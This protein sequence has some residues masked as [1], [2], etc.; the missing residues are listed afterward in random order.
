V[1][2]KRRSSRNGY[3]ANIKNGKKFSREY[4]QISKTR[5]SGGSIMTSSY[6]KLYS[7]HEEQKKAIFHE[8]GMLLNAG[9]GAG[10]TFVII[11]HLVYRLQ[12][13]WEKYLGRLWSIS[14]FEATSTTQLGPPS[15]FWE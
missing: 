10:K 1:R 13:F 12:C 15:Y 7:L 11:E 9:A 4:R 5:E 2:E 8:G 3:N 6:V 14:R